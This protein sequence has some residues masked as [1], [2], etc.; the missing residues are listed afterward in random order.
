MCVPA[1]IGALITAA[2]AAGERRRPRGDV[3]GWPQPR[4]RGQWSTGGLGVVAG[5]AAAAGW[6]NWSASAHGAFRSPGLPA[7]TDFPDWQIAACAV[8]TLGLCL[9]LAGQ[10]ALPRAGALAAATGVTTGFVAAIAVDATYD[11]TG[12]SGVGL[13]M[14]GIGGW[15]VLSVIAVLVATVRA[16]RVETDWT[17]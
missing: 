14:T 11:S 13:I 15:L 3:G 5:F 6:L 7:P 2:V 17:P 10:A 1:V 9:I 12:Q 8:T 4:G 16:A